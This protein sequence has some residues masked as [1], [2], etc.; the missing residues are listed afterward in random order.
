M[1]ASQ[2]S[3]AVLVVLVCTLIA[4]AALAWPK[5]APA[6]ES[7]YAP[8]VI[9][10][11]FDST[12]ARMKAAKPEV[13]KRQM[14]LLKQRYDLSDN[15]AKD[16][17][18]SRGK[19][20]QQAVRVKLPQGVTWQKLAEMTPDQIRQKELFPKGF[21][22]L[23]HPNHQEGGMLFPSFVIDEIKKQESQTQSQAQ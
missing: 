8:V 4:A 12:V 11:D 23:P 6:K 14:D 17:T 10:E 19:P 7:S 1:N 21:L 16:V 22:P 13:M 20:V 18:M 9:T 15:P 3:K 5:A 2:K